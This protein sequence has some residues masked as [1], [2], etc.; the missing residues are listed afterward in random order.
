MRQVLECGIL[1]RVT[2]VVREKLMRLFKI[3]LEI[4]IDD[5][6][7]IDDKDALVEYLNNK[8][9]SDPEWFGEFGPENIE[10]IKVLN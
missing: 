3:T 8:L 1:E 7:V 6:D 4:G 10:E 5:E 2:R 9:Y